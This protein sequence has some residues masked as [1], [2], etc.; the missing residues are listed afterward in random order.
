[1]IIFLRMVFISLMPLLPELHVLACTH[2]INIGDINFLCGKEHVS[3]NSQ[4][5]ANIRS[6]K[7]REGCVHC[8]ARDAGKYKL[9][10]LSKCKPHALQYVY[11]SRTIV[12][13]PVS[14]GTYMCKT[15]LTSGYQ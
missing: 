13:V 8:L 1:M 9:D 11:L 12:H 14:D 10:M 3:F 15:G 2:N 5:T 4:I 6:Q 7:G